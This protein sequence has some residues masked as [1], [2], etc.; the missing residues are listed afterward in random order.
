MY[1]NFYINNIE[2]IQNL[3]KSIDNIVDAKVIEDDSNII[4]AVKT[5]PIYSKSDINI[6]LSVV[7]QTVKSATDKNI[8]VSR[9]MEIF[10]DIINYNDNL[11]TFN[12]ILSKVR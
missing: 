1:C 3:V 4:I 9:N 7:K 12:E 6:L 2:S 10:C 8:Y 11:I 5:K